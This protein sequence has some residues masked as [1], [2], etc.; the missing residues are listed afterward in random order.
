MIFIITSVSLRKTWSLFPNDKNIIIVF[1]DRIQRFQVCFPLCRNLELQYVKMANE[2]AELK[3]KLYELET[4]YLAT[5]T[6][7]THLKQSMLKIQK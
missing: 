2:N 3:H 6:E 4:L 1:F 7:L 5:G